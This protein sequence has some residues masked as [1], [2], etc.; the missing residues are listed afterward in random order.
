MGDKVLLKQEKVDKFSTNF[1]KTPHIVVHKH[2]NQVTVE[3]PEGAQYSSNTTCVKKYI[4]DQHGARE[5]EA[6]SAPAYPAQQQAMNSRDCP[7]A[8]AVPDGPATPASRPQRQRKPPE[9]LKDFIM[10]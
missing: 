8:P 1:N 4:T 7:T 2:G 10:N 3:S 5:R 6:V 9:R